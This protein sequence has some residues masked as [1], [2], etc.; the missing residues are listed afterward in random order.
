MATIRMQLTTYLST[1]EQVTE[2]EIVKNHFGQVSGDAAIL[3]ELIRNKAMDIQHGKTRRQSIERIEDD[4]HGVKDDIRGLKDEQMR[5]RE[6][7]E[8]IARKVGIGQPKTTI[9]NARDNGCDCVV[10]FDDKGME[11]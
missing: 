11:L 2:W 7:L 5:Q 9:V 8:E 6:M 1:D 4:I 3:R 10:E